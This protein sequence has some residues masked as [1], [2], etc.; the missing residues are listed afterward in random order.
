MG[1]NSK[2][3]MQ[4]IKIG[5]E[6]HG[7]LNTEKKLFCNCDSIH[8]PTTIPNTSICPICTGQPGSKP[9]KPNKEAIEKFLQTSLMLNCKIN[10]K[11]RFQRKHYNWPDL[12]KGYQDTISG[13]HSTNPAV[14]GKFENIKIIEAHLEEDPAAWNPETGCIDYNRSGLPLIEIVTYPEFKTSEEVATW[15]KNL[16]LTLSYI[17]TIDK[18]LGLKVDVNISINQ[19][20]GG[21]RVEV[22]NLHSIEEIKKAIEFEIIRQE[23][24][25]TQKE[26][27]RYDSSKNQTTVMRAKENLEDYEFIPDPDLPTITLDKKQTEKIKSSLPESPQQKLKK[28]IKKH[29]INTYSANVLSKN[30]E[31]VEFFEHVAESIPPAFALDWITIELLRVLKYNKKELDQ[32]EINVKH[33]IELLQAVKDKKLT[34]LKAKQ[35]LNQFIPKSFSI[36]DTLKDVKTIDNKSQIETLAKQVIKENPKAVEDFKA[37]EQ[38]SINFLIGQVMRLSERRADFKVAKNILEKL[39]K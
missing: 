3:K 38:K 17:K 31:I 4:D 1:K 25:G 5:L 24:Q 16:I 36:K 14:E 6:I 32:V 12:P 26:T 29:K 11:F 19:E 9:M 10:P 28:L 22:K 39:L 30:L 21:N 33:F 35:I 18:K 8:S 27:R 20:F 13:A 7:Y 15:L 2:N 34:E 37:G 23:K